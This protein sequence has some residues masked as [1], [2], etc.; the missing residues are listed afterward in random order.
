MRASRRVLA[1]MLLGAAAGCVHAA[2]AKPDMAMWR[3]DC[4][5]F[6]IKDFN[7]SGPY[8]MPV[9]CYLIRHGGDY[10]MFDAGLD[11][12]LLGHPDVEDTQTV[13]LERSL[14]DQFAAIGV[15]PAKVTALVVSHYHGDHTGQAS[16]FPNARLVIGAGDAAV[17]RKES[18]G[19]GTLKPWLNGQRKVEEISADRDLT[20]DGKLRVLFT[21]GHTPGHLSMLVKLNGGA[22]VL[23]G[24]MV[25]VHS[26]LA[27]L[28]PPGNHTDKVRGKAEIE[29]INALAA[30]EKA[31]IVVGHDRG[32]IGLLPAFPKA[33]E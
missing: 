24:D 4:G 3:M 21:P 18:N 7:D 20:S 2:A 27:T 33:A 22:Y 30:R 5:Q 28:V 8:S 23:T 10:L 13:S 25:H 12:G 32:D 15:D 9:S 31:T 1:G 17:L 29:R 16:L 14:A 19:G 26:Q 6:D 11:T